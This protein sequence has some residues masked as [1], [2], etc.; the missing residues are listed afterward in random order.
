[1]DAQLGDTGFGYR[2]YRDLRTGGRNIGSTAC[3]ASQEQPDIQQAVTQAIAGLSDRKVQFTATTPQ[4]GRMLPP[5]AGVIEKA[6]PGL[7]RPSAAEQ[8]PPTGRKDC[9]PPVFMLDD[10]VRPGTCSSAYHEAEPGDR[11]SEKS[12]P[13]TGSY[14]DAVSVL[15]LRPPVTGQYQCG[16][17]EAAGQAGAGGGT[18]DDGP[19]QGA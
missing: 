7:M 6:R 3:S 5:E 17:G 14:S 15:G 13:C 11:P 4:N 19:E 1:M 2:A 12:V 8:P 10:W 18:D 9:S 16:Q